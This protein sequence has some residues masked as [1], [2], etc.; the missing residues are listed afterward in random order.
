MY[1][2][3][4]NFRNCAF[5]ILGDFILQ[6]CFIL[7]SQ[8]MPNLVPP[9]LIEQMQSDFIENQRAAVDN[10]CS[11]V[12]TEGREIEDEEIQ[13]LIIPMLTLMKSRE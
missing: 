1:K 3:K 8:T 13:E 7:K 9:G 2:I 11:K 10:L 6:F 4:K 12:F 5:Q